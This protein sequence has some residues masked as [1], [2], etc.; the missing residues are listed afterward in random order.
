MSAKSV[1]SG[2]MMLLVCLASA[3]SVASAEE[4]PP[5]TGQAAREPAERLH[6]VFVGVSPLEPI[7]MAGFGGALEVRVLARVSLGVGAAGGPLAKRQPQEPS[8]EEVTGNV[9]GYMA[10]TF[11]NGVQIGL[12]GTYRA[13]RGGLRSMWSSEALRVALEP[14]DSAGRRI[15]FGLGPVLGVKIGTRFGFS[16]N[17]QLAL[18]LGSQSQTRDQLSGGSS[19]MLATAAFRL[20]PSLAANIGWSF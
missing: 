12:Q 9:I 10:G 20:R 15:F 16:A 18:I 8:Y 13:E 3:A 19:S 4:A 2:L 14:S 1:G 7:T 5:D 6:R 11:D 17:L